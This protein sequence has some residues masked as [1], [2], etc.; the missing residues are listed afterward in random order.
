MRLKFV[1]QGQAI[2][3]FTMNKTYPLVYGGAIPSN[4]SKVLN[5]TS[6]SC[7]LS[8]LDPVKAKGKIV[9]CYD[10]AY[11]D[12]EVQAAGGVGVILIGQPSIFTHLIPATTVN[13]VQGE[14]ILKYINST[15]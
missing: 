1:L 5:L 8:S 3:T 14:A 7:D 2:N 12:Y 15:R 9:V 6:D 11:A 4:I 13:D 10:Y